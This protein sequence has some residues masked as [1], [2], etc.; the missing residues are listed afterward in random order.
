MRDW[1]SSASISSS[2]AFEWRYTYRSF[3]CLPGARGG[4]ERGKRLWWITY[5]RTPPWTKQ[6]VAVF[7]YS[8]QSHPSSQAQSQSRPQS[9]FN[10]G[11]LMPQIMNLPPPSNRRTHARIHSFTNPRQSRLETKRNETNGHQFG[12]PA[13]L[14]PSS[15]PLFISSYLT[16]TSFPWILSYP[17]SIITDKLLIPMF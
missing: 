3:I 2:S 5:R 13:R 17:S 10:V 1:I 11:L 6:S 14:L 16:R 9:Q 8:T 15:G 7:Y 12:R 4:R